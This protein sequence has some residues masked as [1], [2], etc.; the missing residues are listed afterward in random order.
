MSK[1]VHESFKIPK[2]HINAMKKL[3]PV[4]PIDQARQRR[5]STPL[6]EGPRGREQ[7]KIKI[8]KMLGKN[9]EFDKADELTY[10]ELLDIALRTESAIQT[11]LPLVAEAVKDIGLDQAQRKEAGEALVKFAIDFRD[12]YNVVRESCGDKNDRL[13]ESLAEVV[14][15]TDQFDD[16]QLTDRVSGIYRGMVRVTELE[17][18][19]VKIDRDE[20]KTSKRWGV[21]LITAIGSS[22]GAI[23]SAAFGTV[24]ISVCLITCATASLSTAVYKSIKLR[25]IVRERRTEEDEVEEEK[26]K[27]NDLK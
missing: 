20:I 13:A 7:Y 18:S 27:L 10:E 12:R 19:L 1:N 25:R 6:E 14:L 9:G 2:T 21:T 23:L 22:I 16:M 26:A 24:E 11:T 8:L 15:F 3:A 17:A 4:V 5:E